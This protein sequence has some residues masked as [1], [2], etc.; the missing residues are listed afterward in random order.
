MNQRQ[1]QKKAYSGI[2]KSLL[3]EKKDHTNVQFSLKETTR[4]SAH[5][6]YKWDG[7]CNKIPKTTIKKIQKKN[8]TIKEVVTRDYNMELEQNW[9][10]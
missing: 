8:G 5:K 2:I 3:L 10:R 6:V 1:Q 9:Q 4:G 7:K